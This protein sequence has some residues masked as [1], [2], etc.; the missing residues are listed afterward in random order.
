[1]GTDKGGSGLRQLSLDEWKTEQC[2]SEV[3]VRLGG[4]AELFDDYQGLAA[5]HRIVIQFDTFMD[6]RGFSHA[7][8][9]RDLGFSGEIFADGHVLPDQWQ[10]LQRCG[11][12][13]L[14]DTDLAQEAAQLQRFSDGYQADAQ[15]P[16]PRFRR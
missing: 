2:P 9:L 7:R 3:T 4:E 14:V 1:M 12:S 8:K 5:V 10:F 15:Q 6:G 13:G 11:F 16:L